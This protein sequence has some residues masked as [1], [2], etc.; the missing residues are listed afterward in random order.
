MA[1]SGAKNSAIS[2]IIMSEISNLSSQIN[3]LKDAV[4]TIIDNE[5]SR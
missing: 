3:E 5:I 4:S 2:N 1:L